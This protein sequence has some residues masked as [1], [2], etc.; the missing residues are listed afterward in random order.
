MKIRPAEPQDNEAIIEQIRQFRITLARLRHQPPVCPQPA[1]TAELEDYLA[2]QFPIF[3]AVDQQAGVVGYLVCRVDEEVVWVESLYVSEAHRRAGI[4][5]QLYAAAEQ[6]AQD[7]GGDAPYNWIDPDNDIIV[8]FL[9]KRGYNVLNLI[10]L[11]KQRPGE[12]LVKKVKVG[13]QTYYRS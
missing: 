7:L 6:L 12:K 2:K 5:S 11:R 1:A 9:K 3:V 8:Q 4:A 13:D 10:E